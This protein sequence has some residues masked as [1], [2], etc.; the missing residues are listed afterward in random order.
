MTYSKFLI[1]KVFLNI[2]FRGRIG[3]RYIQLN[4]LKQLYSGCKSK[5]QQVHHLHRA[6][7][8]SDSLMGQLTEKNPLKQTR[9][10]PF[11]D[12]SR[13]RSSSSPFSKLSFPKE[14]SG[15]GDKMSL[16]SKV[17]FSSPNSGDGK[18]VITNLAVH[19]LQRFEIGGLFIPLF[20]N[21]QKSCLNGAS[22]YF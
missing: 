19:P 1:K 14:Q 20:I 6:R 12:I 18:V 21:A 8:I 13:C 22:L 5:V 15:Q 16:Y 3:I 17:T 2:I 9:C 4:M 11:E 10:C 7:V